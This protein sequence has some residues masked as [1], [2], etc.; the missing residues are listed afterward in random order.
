MPPQ[1]YWIDLQLAG[2]LAIMARPRA[3]DWLD[4]EISGWRADG[5]D[6]VVSLL[7]QEEVSELGLQRELDLCRARGMEFISF[8]ISDRGVPSSLREAA[9][10][11]G[12]IETRINEGKAIAIH[13]RAGIGR[14]SLIAACAL[15]RLGTEATA[16]FE[17]ISKARGVIVPD[18]DEQREWVSAFR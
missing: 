16:A 11:I 7:E 4:D 13:C 14:S 3:G 18:T 2:R 6:T 8:P 12:S 5:I 9:A 10:L 15:V 1:I 17:A